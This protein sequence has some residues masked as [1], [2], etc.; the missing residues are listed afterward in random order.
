M[1]KVVLPVVKLQEL[2]YGQSFILRKKKSVIALSFALPSVG[3]KGHRQA[4]AAAD[5]FPAPNPL[6]E[7]KY[8]IITFSHHLSTIGKQLRFAFIHYIHK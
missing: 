2:F 3:G 4:A 5:Y 7:I 1:Y 8:F 6:E